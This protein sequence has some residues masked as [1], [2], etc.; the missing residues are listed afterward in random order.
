[1]R[2]L[3]PIVEPTERA[4]RRINRNTIWAFTCLSTAVRLTGVALQK[5]ELSALQD[6][7]KRAHTLR[8]AST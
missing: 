7:N 2:I 8:F 5:H 4:R 1:M 3:L 6:E